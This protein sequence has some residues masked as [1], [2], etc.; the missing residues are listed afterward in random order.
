MRR[1]P[2]LPGTLNSP[3]PQFDLPPTDARCPPPTTAC[4]QLSPLE[5]NGEQGGGRYLACCCKMTPVTYLCRGQAMSPYYGTFYQTFKAPN[6]PQ[7]APTSRLCVRGRR[8]C[9]RITRKNNGLTAGMPCPRRWRAGVVGGHFVVRPEFATKNQ[10]RGACLGSPRPRPILQLRGDGTACR[11]SVNPQWYTCSTS[12]RPASFT[13]KVS[14][15]RR[16][17]CRVFAVS[18]P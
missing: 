11:E 13:T 2:R 3:P 10:D 5:K 18:T 9:C 15:H 1:G 16:M 4:S 14:V 6:Q 8:P 12:T 7:P 17:P